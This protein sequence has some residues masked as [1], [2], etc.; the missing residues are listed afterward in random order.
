MPL[1]IHH[2]WLS[3]L[4]LCQRHSYKP[5]NSTYIYLYLLHLQRVTLLVLCLASP[6]ND[7]IPLLTSSK[8]CYSLL[9]SYFILLHYL[10]AYAVLSY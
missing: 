9:S 6:A 2:F 5:G 7:R 10:G 3:F 8:Y 4:P 1:K